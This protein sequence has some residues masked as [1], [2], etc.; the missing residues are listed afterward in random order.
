M[1]H[2]G[3][4]NSNR[5]SRDKLSIQ[6][7][8]RSYNCAI[9]NLKILSINVCGLK[10]KL[11]TPE[12]VNLINSY[13]IVGV[14]ETRL[15]DADNITIPG[16]TIVCQNR[17]KLSRCRSGGTAVIIRDT[18]LPHV[19][20]GKSDSKL[21]QFFTLQKTLTI[22]Q[23]NIYFGL[24]YIPPA[25]S[26]YASTDPYLE[27][28]TE[29]E[30]YCS[31]CDRII[32]FGDFNSRTGILADYVIA[33]TFISEMNGN[34]TLLEESKYKL[35]CLEKLNIPL[36]RKSADLTTNNY[37]HQL[38]DFCKNN[39]LFILN[40]RL[41]NDTDVPK[42]TCK[43]RSLIDY[44]I[45]SPECIGYIC[46]FQVNEFSS[47]YSDVHCGVAISLTTRDVSFTQSRDTASE[48]EQTVRL[49]DK[50]KRNSYAQNLN[51]NK[52]IRINND[53]DTLIQQ[54]EITNS[55][56][57]HII[58]D[59]E[60]LFQETCKD[61]FGTHAYKKQPKTEHSGNKPW[62]NR[63]CKNARNIYHKIR[64]L[65]NKHKTNYFKNLLKAVSKDYKQTLHRNINKFKLDKIEKLKS[66]KHSNPREY[67]RIINNNKGPKCQA[68]LDD[69]FNYFKKINNPPPEHDETV[70]VQGEVQNYPYNEAINLSITTEEI[71]E[72]V[73]AL[74]NNK[75]PGSDQILNEH[76]KSTL[77]SLLPIYLKLFN[78]IFDDS[79]F[80]ES[81]VLGNIIPI[82]KNKG[83]A[84]NP[85]NYRPI[86]LL[87]CVG[88]LFTRI[89]SNRL[90]KYAEEYNLLNDCQAGFRKGYS[91]TDNLFII[92]SLIDIMKSKR[93]N[94]T[95]LVSILSKLLTQFGETAYGINLKHIA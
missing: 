83:K 66:L 67:W 28:Q 95:A 22:L 84:Q 13:D 55:D 46:D 80:P 74:Q 54:A 35:E 88:K 2:N 47:L 45:S 86:T 65:Y 94:Y 89:I 72:A 75:S 31:S 69:L 34:D 17:Q 61:T 50:N 33:D 70:P 1:E 29:I 15:D 40:G 5:V 85:E 77:S 10:K 16:Y 62:L 91:T 21:I 90:T 53:I 11:N 43:D 18:I 39:Y 81:W 60:S 20:F 4:T 25:G 82:Y 59:I 63:E 12:F 9:T 58:D 30:K 37:G 76:I 24:I 6:S 26:K 56:V 41:E 48:P 36:I 23:E 49:W 3:T 27:I 42:T 78:I 14:Q 32:L 71:T 92:N 87:S 57:N 38:I 44:F 93:Q 52:L 73:A 64:R 19:K 68:P 8:L 79:I 51:E 7:N